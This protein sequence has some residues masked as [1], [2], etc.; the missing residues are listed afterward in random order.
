MGMG[1][2]LQLAGQFGWGGLFIAYLIWRESKDRE[3]AKDRL[4]TDKALVAAMT[5][6][7]AQI[8]GLRQ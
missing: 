6:L 2:V 1:E 5:L 8:N 3:Y 4:E 7:T